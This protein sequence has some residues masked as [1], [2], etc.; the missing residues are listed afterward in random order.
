DIKAKLKPKKQ[1][2]SAEMLD[3]ANTY[4]DKVA[5]IRMIVA[6]ESDR[7]ANVFKSML[8]KDMTS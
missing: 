4:D 7:V 6:D 3:T 2:F 5:V 1:A 8:N